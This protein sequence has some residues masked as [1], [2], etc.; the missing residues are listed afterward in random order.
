[1]H[2]NR[3]ERAVF[4]CRNKNASTLQE[5]QLLVQVLL[6]ELPEQL[7]QEIQ[8]LVLLP[9]YPVLRERLLLVHL[10][11]ERLLVLCLVP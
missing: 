10:L 9:A 1:L 2:K 7:V 8:L 6:E 3:S 4:C 11:G 5:F